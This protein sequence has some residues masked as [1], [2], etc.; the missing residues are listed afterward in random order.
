M[1]IMATTTTRVPFVSATSSFPNQCHKYSLVARTINL[2]VSSASL[3]LSSCYST[4]LV[5]L[6][7]PRSFKGV[8]R[9]GNRS[10][11]VVAMAE[12]S[13]STVLVTGAGGRTGLVFFVWFDGFSL[14]SLFFFALLRVFGL[15]NDISIFVF[16]FIDFVVNAGLW[17]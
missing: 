16:V 6:A 9:G 13:K 12:S 15:E 4:S 14:N 1:V 7:L 17:I 2:P 3:R 5:S 8:K 11:V 10:V